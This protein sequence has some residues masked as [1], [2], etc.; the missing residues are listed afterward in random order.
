MIISPLT[1]PF[2]LHS[3]ADDVSPK[4]GGDLDCQSYAITVKG[5]LISDVSGLNSFKA[6]VGN[7]I[8]L[9]SD[10]SIDRIYFADGGDIYLSPEG[11]DVVIT[12]NI[13][14]GSHDITCD[15][16]TAN[17]DL[18]VD[19]RTSIG[20]IGAADTVLHLKGDHISGV[21]IL[22]IQGNSNQHAFMC[23]D[24]C[25]SSKSAGYI[26]RI[27]G[28]EKF[29][30]NCPSPGA[31]IGLY[32]YTWGDYPCTFEDDGDVKFPH[33]YDHTVGGTNVDL[34]V[35]DNGYIGKQ[36]SGAAYKE[37]IKDLDASDRIY[38]LRPVRYDRK[39]GSGK[40][41]MGLIAEEVAA[42]MPEAVS[43][44]RRAVKK[45]VFDEVSGGEIEVI[46]HYETTDTPESV[47]YT[48]LIPAM[49]KE[50]QRLRQEINALKV[51]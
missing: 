46:D 9:Q 5:M 48:R 37:N 26:F 28:S 13:S 23:L 15:N 39:D 41:M 33:A 25:G 32:S 47:S 29:Y 40:N 50:I 17:E 45:R 14:M 27:D 1:D 7:G 6:S 36:P 19:S 43:F 35:D 3:L 2:A 18:F 16:L 22:K 11:G 20:H 42:V 4:L 24:S 51:V 12:G 21:G 10:D 38:Q 49:L 31:K 30:W 44:E 8:S 34:Y